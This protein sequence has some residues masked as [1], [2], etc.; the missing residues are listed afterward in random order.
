MGN[1][2][3]WL[4]SNTEDWKCLHLRAWHEKVSKLFSA[5]HAFT[6]QSCVCSGELTAA[7]SVTQ[8][9]LTALTSTGL[10][11]TQ[12]A[13]GE[14]GEW[15]TLG[16][17]AEEEKVKRNERRA[18]AKGR[19]ERERA[20]NSWRTGQSKKKRSRRRENETD[21]RLAISRP[22]VSGFQTLR[23]SRLSL[24]TVQREGRRE[25]ETHTAET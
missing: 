17:R 22:R 18:R 13:E 25:G 10:I 16:E 6:G 20:K 21:L 3:I 1:S 11:D 15:G 4:T 8:L 12:G 9:L 2:I 24:T 14:V 19:R 23:T 7:D 5:Q